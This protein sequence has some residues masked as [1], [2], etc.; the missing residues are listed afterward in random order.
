[1]GTLLFEDVDDIRMHIALL[2]RIASADGVFHPAER[3][4][5]ETIADGYAKAFGGNPFAVMEQTLSE[6]D[7]DALNAW[8]AGIS[9]KPRMARNLI[10][11][12]ISL[13]YV[14]GRYCDKENSAVADAAKRL[15]VEATIVERIE[16]AVMGAVAAMADL[17]RCVN[18]G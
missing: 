17:S 14:D 12:M 15:G 4:F 13:G 16:K 1:M 8:M 11:D 6:V 18:E 2:V 3:R 7:A 9:E 10:K 5:V